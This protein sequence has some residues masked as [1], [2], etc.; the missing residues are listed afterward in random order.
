[1]IDGE[2]YEIF[3]PEYTWKKKTVTDFY[4]RPLLKPIFEKGK[5][6]YEN[7]KLDVLKEYC[8][9]EVEGLWEEVKRFENPHKY[10][11]DMSKKLWQMKHDMLEKVQI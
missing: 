2:K 6:V 10:Y 5:L 7:P 11:V 8:K 1:M 3:D 4:A 9:M